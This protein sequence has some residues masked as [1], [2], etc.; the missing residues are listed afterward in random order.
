MNYGPSITDVY[1]QLGIYTG[2]FSRVKNL[3]IF[4]FYNRPN[5]IC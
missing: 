2:G 1:R 4:Q 5:S 3:P